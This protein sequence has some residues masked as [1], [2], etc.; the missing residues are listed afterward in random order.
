MSRSRSP[1]GR[2]QAGG[3]AGRWGSSEGPACDQPRAPG[4]L[5]R[6]GL[7][8][9]GVLPAPM[10][11]PRRVQGSCADRQCPLDL[12][13]RTKATPLEMLEAPGHG[14]G[15]PH[16]GLSRVASPAGL[17]RL[18]HE[19]RGPQRLPLGPG[20]RSLGRG[21][22]SQS[23]AGPCPSQHALQPPRI[24]QSAPSSARAARLSPPSPPSPGPQCPA[25][26]RPALQAPASESSRGPS[27]LVTVDEELRPRTPRSQAWSQDPDPHSR[28]LKPQS[29]RDGKGLEAAQGGAV[30]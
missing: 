5:A 11:P 8:W 6:Q 23:A 16:R 20:Q 13:I 22:H 21:E 18:S 15:G 28:A 2:G 14:A 7:A 4:G 10:L 17:G 1:A 19:A 24:D 25:P 12:L 29:R 3:G 26:P 30:V 9:Q 27:E